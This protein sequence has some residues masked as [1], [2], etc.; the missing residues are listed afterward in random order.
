MFH[1][2][3]DFHDTILCKNDSH[4]QNDAKVTRKTDY[5]MRY[6]VANHFLCSCVYDRVRMDHESANKLLLLY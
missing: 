4:V 5:V 6:C 2:E 1:C 3:I